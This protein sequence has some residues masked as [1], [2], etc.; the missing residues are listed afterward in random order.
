[1]SGNNYLGE[2]RTFAYNFVPRD[3][4][5]C[6]GQLL[7]RNSQTAALFSLLGTTYGGDG[8]NNFALPNLQGRAPLHS[9]VNFGVT[10]TLGQSLGEFA[11]VLTP[12][13]IMPH[14]HTVQASSANAL[15]TPI[16]QQPGSTVVLAVASVA[17]SGGGVDP[18]SIYG[19]GPGNVP[20]GP[21][22]APS[23]GGFG[24]RKSVV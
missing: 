23:A 1:M 21:A 15:T 6:N 8:L 5:P 13:E 3:W 14:T 16:G 9:G 2:I 11:H 24:D 20:M 18:V 10:C 7:P 19:T 22:V 4:A 17:K 12:N